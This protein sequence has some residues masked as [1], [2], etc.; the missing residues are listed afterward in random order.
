[1]NAPFHPEALRLLIQQ[2]LTHI[3]ID[4]VSQYSLNAEEL[5][6][7]TSAN[8]SNLGE[9]RTQAPN[10]PARG[11]FQMEAEDFNDIWAN[12]LKYK[13]GLA[14]Y[15]TS[16]NNGVQGTVDDLVNNDKYAIVMA[17]IHYD[18]APGSLPAST[19]IESIWAYYKAHYNTP[20]GAATHDQFM[21]K[22]NRYVKAQG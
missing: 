7:A 6:M 19:D 21:A 11:I 8:E 18:R 15:A 22:Y 5:L 12:Y 9:Y 13:T 14:I 20:Q 17:R 1:M 3:V 4:G 10:G 2:T 16:F